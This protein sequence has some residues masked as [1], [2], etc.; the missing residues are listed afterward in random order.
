MGIIGS[1]GNAVFHRPVHRVLI[2]AAGGNIHKHAGLGVAVGLHK[3]DLDD[4]GSSDI[5]KGVGLHRA[6]AL[7]VDLD[8]GDSIAL[9]RG[10]G[11]GL[12]SALTDA[13]AAGGRNGAA[14]SG[15]RIDGV[16]AVAAAAIVGPVGVDGGFC[17]EYGIRRDLC[18][19]ALFGVPTVEAVTAASGGAGQRGQFL[20]G[21]GHAADRGRT[22]VT[23]KGDDEL[24][25]S[26]RRD[27][28]LIAADIAVR[29]RVIIVDM[30]RRLLALVGIRAIFSCAD[31]GVAGFSIGGPVTV[32]VLVCRRCHG[33]LIAA[34]VADRICIAVVDVR[35]RLLALVGIR[36]IFGCAGAGVGAVAV[37]RP[38]AEVM[39]ERVAVGLVA[40]VADCL[41]GA[42]GG[43]ACM[44]LLNGDCLI[45]ADPIALRGGDGSDKAEA[46]FIL[47]IIGRNRPRAEAVNRGDRLAVASVFKLIAVA[48]IRAALRQPE[49]EGEVLCTAHGIRAGDREFG[50]GLAFGFAAAEF[51]FSPILPVLCLPLVGMGRMDGHGK[52]RG[53]ARLV[54]GNDGLR[55]PR[56]G[57]GDLALFVGGHGI[58]V[59]G[60]GVQIQ[61][62][63][64]E[65][66]VA[67]AAE[68]VAVLRAADR[69][70]GLVDDDLIRIDHNFTFELSE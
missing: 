43:A 38:R 44:L 40:G 51:A 23:V 26:R 39:A 17:R 62:G 42:G 41:L 1:L 37:G 53:I 25:G 9:I 32:S 67:L 14:S 4:M 57:E 5:L 65:G 6:D 3:D 55:C 18:A 34:F 28:A 69:R 47:I 50:D 46:A 58:T 36:A 66:L 45:D 49:G 24:G 13:D 48:G 56:V 52:C 30:R 19:A 11:E 20:I 15:S 59:D 61:V 31:A 27:G 22:A 12:I 70:G 29:I 35:F 60:H 64:G 33:A 2:I 8:I 10:D 21:C 7:A 68:N 63:Y 16:V 54:R